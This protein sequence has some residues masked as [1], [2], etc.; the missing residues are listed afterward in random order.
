MVEG[1][2]ASVLSYLTVIT[3]SLCGGGICHKTGAEFLVVD[4]E[5]MGVEEK[6]EEGMGKGEGKVGGE[7]RGRGDCVKLHRTPTHHMFSCRS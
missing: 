4:G 2:S 1:Q 7:R 3:P 5:G 6:G